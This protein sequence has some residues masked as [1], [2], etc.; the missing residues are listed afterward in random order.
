MNEPQK[1]GVCRQCGKETDVR[2]FDT[3]KTRTGET[4]RRGVCKDC[5]NARQFTQREKK[6][7]WRREHYQKTKT[8][9]QQKDAARRAV[10]KAYVDAFK[11]RPCM[12][13]GVTWP[14]VA[15]DLD[16]VRGFKTKNVATF[17]SGA[18]RLEL[19][20]EEIEKCDVVCACCHRIRTA[21]RKDNLA[22]PSA[23]IAL[24]EL[25]W[26]MRDE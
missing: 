12:D 7:Q 23:V 17:V 16:H 6:E 9:K 10:I 25:P 11:S 26:R 24:S 21:R 20:K 22:P 14:P 5:R 4:R 15:M 1:N 18:Y 13:C 3:F 8:A 2:R 19:V